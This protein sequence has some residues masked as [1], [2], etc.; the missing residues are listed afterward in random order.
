MGGTRT[1]RDLPFLLCFG[2]LGGVYVVLIAAMLAADVCFTSPGHVLSALASPQIRYA[3]RL[4]LLSCTV[5]TILSLWTAIPLGYLLART[6]FPGK[7]LVDVLL[8]IPIVLPPLVVGLSLLIL[9]R[10]PPMSQLQR[11]VPIMFAIPG[12]LLA[13][14]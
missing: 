8:D 9:F 7:A 14:Y 2:V 4:S 1:L 10:L 6:S 3:V 12:V 11:A 13:Q 5:T